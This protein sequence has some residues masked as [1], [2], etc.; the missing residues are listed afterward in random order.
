MKSIRQKIY[1]IMQRELR[2]ILRY[3]LPPKL[4]YG[5]RDIFLPGEVYC[6]YKVLEDLDSSP[7]MID[8]GAHVG[9]SLIKFAQSGWKIFAFE[10]DNQNRQKLEKL[11]F[12][13]NLINVKIDSR[14]VS[15]ENKKNLNFFRS[16]MS[17]GISGLTVFDSTHES[18][19]EVETITLDQFC[20]KN[21][22]KKVNFLKIDTEGWD[23]FVLKGFPFERMRPD[24]IMAEFE[25]KKT[26]PLGY[27]FDEMAQ[28]L[29]GK[30]YHVAVSEW[31]PVI[32][33]GGMHKFRQI[34][35]YPVKLCDPMAT[36]N[37][38]AAVNK[39]KLD[40]VINLIARYVK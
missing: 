27:T 19:Q 39:V 3:L 4:Y 30:G 22:I 26:V 2:N 10:P 6:C 36:G 31:Y 13:E 12:R 37:L 32:Q 23:L 15:N 14:A 8:V 38:I 7:V 35:E 29:V 18:V 33:Y 5:L 21:K 20:N 40:E 34:S 25:D 17:S 11:C 16:D 1:S 24:V 28:Y 9:G